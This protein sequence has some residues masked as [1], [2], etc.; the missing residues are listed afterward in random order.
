MTTRTAL[1]ASLACVASWA[2]KALAMALAGGLGRSPLEDP[3]FYVGFLALLVAAGAYGASLVAHRGR[4][5]HVAG[6]AGGL[7]GAVVVTLVAG[8]L[9]G[10]LE[11][12]HAGWV[13]GEVNLW[14]VA[15]VVLLAAVSGVRRGVTRAGTA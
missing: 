12:A 7:I 5:L 4:W 1:I 9:V 10:V 3:L 6:A 11:P 15:L 13:W 8:S 14:V 2:A